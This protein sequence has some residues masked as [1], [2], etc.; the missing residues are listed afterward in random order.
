MQVFRSSSRDKYGVSPVIGNVMIIMIVVIS[1]GIILSW[2]IPYI[3]SNK[4]D[5]NKK[6]AFSQLNIMEEAVV[7]LVR[8]GYYNSVLNKVQLQDASIMI[9]HSMSRLVVTYSLLD[10]D[11]QE[12]TFFVRDLEDIYGDLV[13]VM[14]NYREETI[15]ID[16][17]F[18]YQDPF[19]SKPEILPVVPVI[20]KEEYEGYPAFIVKFDGFLKGTV[21]ID[22]YNTDRSIHFGRILIFD[23]GNIVY[24]ISSV[25]GDQQYII[26]NGGII[27]SFG[28]SNFFV[29]EP[30][31][32]KESNITSLR[33]MQTRSDSGG[34]GGSGSYVC[35]IKSELIYNNVTETL[36]PVYNLIFYFYG[37]YYD[38]WL[39]YLI[40]NHDFLLLE[41]REDWGNY[42]DKNAVYYYDN[43]V[44]NQEI[45]LTVVESIC[46]YDLY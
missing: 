37:D 30:L 6:T 1:M 40:S 9:N 43:F 11:E 31:F 46:D 10:N 19:T 7:N 29:R 18:I 34:G 32:Y 12:F 27:S 39:N 20:L 22:L 41:L 33:V 44:K 13:V 42:E 25:E 35:N 14:P 24:E 23:L 45:L 3:E 38:V 15:C 4:L 5:A 8:E 16:F 36:A 2:G 26:E 28:G 17:D 21:F